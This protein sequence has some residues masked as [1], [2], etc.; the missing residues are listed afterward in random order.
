MA[1]IGNL[2]VPANVSPG[3]PV[4]YEFVEDLFEQ[5]T[6]ANDASG[7]TAAGTSI[8]DATTNQAL[9]TVPWSVVQGLTAG[10]VIELKS[11]GIMSAPSSGQ[12]TLAFNGYTNGSGGTALATMT[13]FTPYASASAALWEAYMRVS[14]YSATTVQCIIRATYQTAGTPT[15]SSYLA[16][17]NSA[18]AVT[19]VSGAAISLAAVMG[20]AVS[21]SSFRALDGSWDQT[22]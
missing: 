10:N 15:F 6:S 9:V 2:V 20:S 8:S 17:N 3:S 4:T 19:L 14:W 22:A 21:G 18:T 12:A 13:A 7:I 16:G 1:T 11:Y 5:I